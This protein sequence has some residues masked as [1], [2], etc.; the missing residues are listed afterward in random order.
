MLSERLKYNCRNTPET[1]KGERTPPTARPR[2]GRG[3]VGRGWGSCPHR[4]GL[5]SGEAGGVWRSVRRAEP[6]AGRAWAGP[7]GRQGEP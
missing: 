4:E 5:G 3:S 6:L 7:C 1:V 2:K